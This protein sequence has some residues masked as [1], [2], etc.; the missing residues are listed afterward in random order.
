VTPERSPQKETTMK[1]KN[2]LTNALSINMIAR[3]LELLHIMEIEPKDV[4]K[5]IECAI[6]HIDTAKV[7]GD[8]LGQ[9]L[10]ARRVNIEIDD[11][12]FIYVAQYR[13]PRLPE[14]TTKLPEGAEIKFYRVT[15]ITGCDGCQGAYGCNT[16][17][18]GGCP[19]NKNYVG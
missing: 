3:D 1:K 16:R 2:I 9:D 15:T 8:V 17:G 5:D 7:V 18:T 10:T 6:G 19:M 11:D 14:G 4:P 12:S 13:G